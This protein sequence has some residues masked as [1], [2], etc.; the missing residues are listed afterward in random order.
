MVSIGVVSETP[1]KWGAQFE[2]CKPASGDDV[3]AL[4]EN[5]K[6]IANRYSAN[7]LTL[8][9]RDMRV[10]LMSTGQRGRGSKYTDDFKRKLVSESSADG[11]NVPVVAKKHG[12][13]DNRINGWRGDPRFQPHGDEV[14]SFTPVDI[15]DADI[16]DTPTSSV[17]SIL[18]VGPVTV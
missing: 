4:Y 11:V 13:P 7:S 8:C 2:K 15:A 17:T 6:I 10:L 1:N 12:V 16:V 3:N 18:H 5:P 14:A 9:W